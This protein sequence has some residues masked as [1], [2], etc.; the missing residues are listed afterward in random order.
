[1]LLKAKNLSTAVN[2][3]S[4]AAALCINIGLG[5]SG[6]IVANNAFA[7]DEAAT[8]DPQSTALFAKVGDVEITREQYDQSFQ[9]AVRQKFYHQKPPEAALDSI[10]NEVADEIITHQLLLQAAQ[11]LGIKADDSAINKKIEQ[12]DR[13]Y[14]DSARWQQQRQ[15]LTKTLR[16]NLSEEDILQQI[17]KQIRNIAPPSN[18]QLKQFYQAN[19]EKFTEP[20][21]QKLSLILLLVD[22]SST[23]AVWD[24]ADKEAQALVTQLR[25]GADFAELAR[26]HSGDASAAQG[27]D[28]GYIH[29]EMLAEAAQ[30]AVDE[31]KPGEITE[32][33]EVLQGVAILRLE[34][35]SVE[36]LRAFN[37]VVDRA[38][39]LWLRDKSDAAWLAFKQKLRQDTPVTLYNAMFNGVY[40][41]IL[42]E[43]QKNK[44]FH[45]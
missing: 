3:R 31:L 42:N 26:M 13:R 16:K 39:A 5:L 14:A 37:D 22:P 8:I 33:V 7:A 6:F 43:K 10:H 30:K 35:R 41:G 38:R 40:N 21:Q 17:E 12:Y 15:T 11:R 18:V 4:L 34:D 20:A 2:I 23:T 29:R 24:A 19:P 1:M 45:A 44:T 28:M 25:N 9:L 36:R 32:A 27:G